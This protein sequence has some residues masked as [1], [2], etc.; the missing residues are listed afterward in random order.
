MSYP[1][2]DLDEISTAALEAELASRRAN[3][4]HGVC[5]YCYRP[6]DTKPCRFPRRH[7]GVEHA[8]DVLIKALDQF[9]VEVVVWHDREWGGPDVKDIVK[10]GAKVAEEAGEVVGAAIKIDEG[11]DTAQHLADEAGDVVIALATACSRAGVSLGD[12]VISR[13]R[14]DVSHR[15]NP[16]K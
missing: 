5:D 13:W 2:Y 7:S 12:A 11:R 1:F 9:Q 3:R 15:V 8:P 4:R 10:A 6:Y 16:N 14:N